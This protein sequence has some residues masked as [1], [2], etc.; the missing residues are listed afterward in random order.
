MRLLLPHTQL[1]FGLINTKVPLSPVLLVCH[2]VYPLR[3]TESLPLYTVDAAL[4]KIQLVVVNPNFVG[5]SPNANPSLEVFW[6]A[7][8]DPAVT[9][10]VRYSRSAGTVTT[11]P[12]EAGQRSANEN[13]VVLSANLAPNKWTPYANYIWVAAVSAGVPMGEYSNRTQGVTLHSEMI[14]I[15]H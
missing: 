13:A 6:T 9:F 7:V 10:V 15:T 14:V 5:I 11:P 2:T 1:Q 12:D 3:H 4:P 8:N